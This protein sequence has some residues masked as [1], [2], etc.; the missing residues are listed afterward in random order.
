MR[1]QDGKLY[2]TKQGKRYRV[3]EEADGQFTC[4]SFGGYWSSLG[5]AYG[6]VAMG[7]KYRTPHLVREI[8]ESRLVSAKFEAYGQ[9]ELFGRQYFKRVSLDEAREIGRQ[10]H[11]KGLLKRVAFAAPVKQPTAGKVTGRDSGG[12]EISFRWEFLHEG[13]YTF[14]QIKTSGDAVIKL[15]L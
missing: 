8:N 6:R 2:E 1:L 4:K 5:E 14:L 11:E 10:G 12:F 15:P 13:D 7:G 3:T 9:F